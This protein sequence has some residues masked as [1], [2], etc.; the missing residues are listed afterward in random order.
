MNPDIQRVDDWRGMYV[1]DLVTG[2]SGI[3][4]AYTVWL[5]DCIRIC[6]TPSAKKTGEQIEELWVDWSQCKV[7]NEQTDIRVH[8]GHD[9]TGSEAQFSTGG[10][11][12]DPPKVGQK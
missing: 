1:M 7:L 9:V 11:M 5:N 2:A 10:P 12:N 3:C 6:L 4:S 8:M